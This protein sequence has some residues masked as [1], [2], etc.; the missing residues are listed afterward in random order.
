MSSPVSQP[1]KSPA[2]AGAKQKI[3]L[4][5]LRL[6]VFSDDDYRKLAQRDRAIWNLWWLDTEHTNGGMEQVFSNDTG[7]RMEATIEAL[8]AVGAEK[9]AEALAKACALFPGG[10][11]AAQNEKRRQQ[12]SVILDRN[13][14]ALADFKILEE[15]NFYEKTL[16]YWKKQEPQSEPKSATE[17][18]RREVLRAFVD[19]PLN[20]EE[21]YAKLSERQRTLWDICW[22]ETS[23]NHIGG[24]VAYFEFQGDHAPQTLIALERIGATK[25][26]KM[27]KEVC[28]YYPD[29][30]PSRDPSVRAE[31]NAKALQA[32][33]QKYKKLNAKDGVVKQ[34][35]WEENLFELLLEYWKKQ[36]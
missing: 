11:P 33:I 30:R 34:E 23:L 19:L 21:D 20:S 1:T 27:F 36:K 17:K 13:P 32:L 18:N 22:F 8:R 2:N 35:D 14:N 9:S 15:P 6:P 31:Q 28:S 24:P 29:G 10:V 4:L 5:F 3:R 25:S 12:L 16:E 26:Q 7:G